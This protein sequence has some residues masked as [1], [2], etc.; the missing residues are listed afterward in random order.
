VNH[1]LA[2][3]KM[4]ENQLRANRVTEEVLVEAL[5]ELPRERFVPRALAG[6]AY[7][8]EDLAVAPGRYLLEPM[9]LGRLVQA[10]EIA[11]G[12]MV[13]DLACATGYSTA[14]LA[15][16]GGT[17]VAVEPDAGLAQLANDTLNALS[18]DNAV[19]V[20][21]PLDQGY[22]KQAPYDAVLL[23]GAVAVVPPALFDQLAEGGRLVAVIKDR[24]GLGRATLFRKQGGLMGHR[25]L[26]DAG[27]PLLPGFARAP[28]FVF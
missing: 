25:V 28:G 12:E 26:F 20:T 18:V 7:V 2:R 15:R 3:R 11:P 4:V 5:S 21:G 23:N 24:P 10:L 6:I 9:V 22:A 27:T 13:L 8:D 16:L 1:A 19:V 17:V 14:V